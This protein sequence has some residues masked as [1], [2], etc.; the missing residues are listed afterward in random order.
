MNKKFNNS[1]YK[2]V[3][4][5]VD[6]TS[7]NLWLRGSGVWDKT[8]ELNLLKNVLVVMQIE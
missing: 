2:A 5:E 3:I 7:L 8:I 6:S 1:N 4:T